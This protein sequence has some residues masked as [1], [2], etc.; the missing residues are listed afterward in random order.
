[1]PSVP[2]DHL[3]RVLACPHCRASLDVVDRTLRCAA[4]HAFDV[5][6]QGYVSLFAR[7]PRV[8]GDLPAMVAARE[9]VEDAG[10]LESLERRVAEVVRQATSREPVRVALDAGGGTG[11]LLAAVLADA[12]DP[13]P[14]DGDEGWA[15]SP[16]VGGL[17]LDL[18]APA[19]RRAARRGPAVAAI[20]VDLWERWPVADGSVDVVLDVFAPRNP[21]EFHRVLRPTG[22]LVVVTPGP[23]HLREVAEPVGLVTVDP[24][25]DAR[26]DEQFSGMFEAQ[27]REAVDVIQ[28]VSHDVAVDLVAMG[29]AGVHATRDEI[30]T[31]LGPTSLA[32]PVTFSWV[33]RWY[34]PRAR[35]A[36]VTD[37][38]A[39]H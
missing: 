14:H 30:S 27:G 17:V 19:L 25:K 24:D 9:R 18:S 37:A 22:T 15:R 34:R 11:H 1:M 4:G 35:S 6:R 28:T 26:V 38:A 36:A 20:R 29:P 23:G 39:G 3:V 2:A 8:E 32:R 12:F 13:E 33:C 7:A 16:S 31:R 21:P 5:A 10:L